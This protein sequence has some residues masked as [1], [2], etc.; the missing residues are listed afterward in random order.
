[1]DPAVLSGPGPRVDDDRPAVGEREAGSEGSGGD[2]E[3]QQ[4]SCQ[5]KPGGDQCAVRRPPPAR[6]AVAV[7]LD[8]TQQP[9]ELPDLVAKEFRPLGLLP[10]SDSVCFEIEPVFILR[11]Y[12]TWSTPASVW[13]RRRS[14]E[15]KKGLSGSREIPGGEEHPGQPADREAVR[16]GPFLA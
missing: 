11:S 12:Q 10:E 3:L 8:G 7:I 15:E 4:Q 13:I 2:G 6:P 5:V 16:S 9:F 1:M 14:A